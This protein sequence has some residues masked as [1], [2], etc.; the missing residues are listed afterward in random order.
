MPTRCSNPLQV[1]TTTFH[2]FHPTNWFLCHFS[3]TMETI[4]YIPLPSL[5]MWLQSL[6]FK[7]PNIPGFVIHL[8]TTIVHSTIMFSFN[9]ALTLH[10]E[11]VFC[12]FPG[13]IIRM[14]HFHL[15][16]I[17]LTLNFI[18]TPSKAFGQVLSKFMFEWIAWQPCFSTI[19]SLHRWCCEASM[20]LWVQCLMWFPS[21]FFFPLLVSHFGIFWIIC[22]SF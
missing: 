18:F 2:E 17:P 3:H 20:Q 12:G 15:H 9:Q 4:H 5:L 21:L 8:C 13:C 11:K 22:S 16:H 6:I 10:D 7:A 1:V 19:W 14:R